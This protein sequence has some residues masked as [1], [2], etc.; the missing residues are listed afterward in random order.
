MLTADLVHTR[1]QGGTLRIVPLG[2]RRERAEALAREV[3]DVAA[4]H[5]GRTLA[6]LEAAWDA[7]ETEP[8]DRKLRDGLVKLVLDRL[9]VGAETE[10]S[11]AELRHAVFSRATAARRALGEGARFDRG[12]VLVE[13]GAAYGMTAEEVEAALFSD[14]RGAHVV[15]A[16]TPHE[17]V[18]GGAHAL[19]LGY[20]L[21]QRQA[22]L[23]RAT[24]LRVRLRAPEPRALRALFRT[25]KFHR[26]LFEVRE[27]SSDEEEASG[28]D[29]EIV[30]D[31][32]GPFSLFESVTKYG[33]SLALAL[34]AIEASGDHVLEADVRWGRERMPLR[35][36]CE[37]SRAGAV[38]PND[39]ARGRGAPPEEVGALVE[40][41]GDRSARFAC[42]PA[43]VVLTL[44]GVGVCVPDLVFTHVASK[45]RV[46][47]EVLG[48]WSRDAVW[49]RVEL[50]EKG[51]AEPV[52]FCASERLRVSEAVLDR[53]SARLLVYK[54][55][56][57]PAALEE[58]LAE[59][60]GR[61]PRSG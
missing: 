22:V 29:R 38:S 27:A 57:S 1:R 31:L 52:V 4:A 50:A 45:R 32:D 34:P 26:L 55:A 42:A 7:I 46:Y 37:G 58:K 30:L 5:L 49:K 43:D 23:L 36:T 40:R 17:I 35:F 51:L 41:W 2:A 15:R 13:V 24:H 39:E 60:V 9:D 8:R 19:V 25:L 33:L 59:L 61:D 3:I 47:V 20:D 44:P 11:P 28:G 53:P 21:A 48:Y 10:E 14:L 54:G 6:E 56:I 18:P 12:A 16:A